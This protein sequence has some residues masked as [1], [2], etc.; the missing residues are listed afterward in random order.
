MERGIRTVDIGLDAVNEILQRVEAASALARI[1]AEQ[2]KQIDPERQGPWPSAVAF[3]ARIRR[4]IFDALKGI[5]AATDPR[6]IGPGI[7]GSL[8]EL[9][10][11]SRGRYPEVFRPTAEREVR[12]FERELAQ[13]EQSDEDL[14]RLLKQEFPL[15]KQ[16]RG[17][18]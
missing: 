11:V 13:S 15:D 16:L 1:Y 4:A 14:I 6:S 5:A 3:L 18:S 10:R 8:A 9:R 7:R 12:K 17:T 2:N